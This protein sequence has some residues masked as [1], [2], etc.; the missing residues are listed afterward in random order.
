VPDVIFD[1]VRQII[2]DIFAVPAETVGPMSSPES[3]E[4]WD[5]IS[6]LNLIL[7]LEQGFGISFTPYEIADLISVQAICQ[8]V[9]QK[10]SQFAP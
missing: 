6:H 9:K 2:A 4:N 10:Q 7:A 8:K 5:S 1:T 3:I